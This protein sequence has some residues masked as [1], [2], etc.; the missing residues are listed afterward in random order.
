[1]LYDKR[2]VPMTAKTVPNTQIEIKHRDTGAVI[3]SRQSAGDTFATT[4][5]LAIILGV[6]VRHAE[7]AN[8]DLSHGYFEDVNFAYC[9]FTG[10]NLTGANFK[11]ARFDHA[12]MGGVVANGAN[13]ERAIFHQAYIRGASFVGANMAHALSLEGTWNEVDFSYADLTGF[14]TRGVRFRNLNLFGAIVDDSDVRINYKWVKPNV[15][16]VCDGPCQNCV[17]CKSPKKT[18]VAK[19][20]SMTRLFNE[21]AQGEAS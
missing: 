4:L 15:P 6:D 17:G 14:T 13:F 7:L 1:M 12:S 11:H 9:D 20:K 21:Y 8:Q 19:Q 16:C 18:V 2:A 3:F 10:A 5:R